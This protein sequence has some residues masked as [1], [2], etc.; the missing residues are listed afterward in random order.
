MEGLEWLEATE[1]IDG[2]DN[3]ER[4]S[5]MKGMATVKRE[6]NSRR[7]KGSMLPGKPSYK[8]E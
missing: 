1:R 7:W 5:R 8:R 4:T 3:D 6:W 2:N